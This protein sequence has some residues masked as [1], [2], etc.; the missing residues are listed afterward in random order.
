MKL[1]AQVTVIGAG[2]VGLAIAAELANHRKSS[3][4]VLEAAESFG[5][6]T[7][8]RNSEIVHAGIYYT[9]GSLKAELCIEG[10]DRL[11]D[12]C[13]KHDVPNRVTG[14]LIVASKPSEE[15][16]LDELLA[17]AQQNGARE[18]H[19]LSAREVAALE[20]AVRGSGALYSP[21]TGIV[22]SHEFM[23]RLAERVQASE[24]ILLYRSPVVG[25][26]KTPFGY[27]VAVG[28]PQ[29]Y[30]FISQLVINAAGL[31]SDHVA[32]MAGFDVDSLD[33]R[34]R[35]CKGSYFKYT[36][37]SPV[38]RPVYPLPNR[39]LTGL[40]VHAT[41]DLEGHL[42][43]GPDVE[44]LPEH[45][46]AEELNYDV[47]M[48][49]ADDFFESANGLIAGLEREHF[50]P[51]FSGVRPKLRGESI[52]D[53]VI[54][55]EADRGWTGFFNL[56]GIESPGLTASLAIASRIAREAAPMLA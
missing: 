37:R 10:A 47:D 29:P 1:D 28:G 13:D 18:V 23:R 20:P 39:H 24:A 9:P 40:G 54:R 51:D 16:A 12:F 11:Y 42:R 4:V 30:R 27:E 34:L 21:R 55:H 25:L 15:A 43:F 19:L 53:F 14:K 3:I 45:L 22:N 52:R 46:S 41:L 17:R 56:I 33:Y 2:V 26:E 6:G 50:V 49:K 36:A 44:F 38:K 5:Q 7:S 48:S 8:S 35:F 31:M 32:A